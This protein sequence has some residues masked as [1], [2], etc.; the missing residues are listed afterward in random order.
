M[1]GMEKYGKY[2]YMVKPN[3]EITRKTEGEIIGYC[4]KDVYNN[5]V[6]TI[7]VSDRILDFNGKYYCMVIYE[8]GKLPLFVCSWEIAKG[9]QENNP[10]AQFVLMHEL[11]HCVMKGG[12]S[13][14]KSK[15]K[16]K[17]SL[18]GLKAGKV[19]NKELL[20]DAFAAEYVGFEDSIK[21]LEET[22]DD[23]F[24]KLR[25]VVPFGDNYPT[26]VYNEF[27]NRIEALKELCKKAKIE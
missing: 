8:K 21:A 16:E 26:L 22:R 1:C 11:G 27:S 19:Q 3:I 14:R 2:A 18:E 10:T 25:S 20:A 23:I 9:L 15:K 17:H 12:N 24:M 5:P 6:M 4:F 7:L 13:S